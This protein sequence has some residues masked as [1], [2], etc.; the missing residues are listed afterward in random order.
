MTVNATIYTARITDVSLSFLSLTSYN[1]ADQEQNRGTHTVKS[2]ST[3][4][5]AD[6]AA[7]RLFAFLSQANSN[8]Q[9][10]IRTKKGHK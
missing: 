3:N 1:N 5:A 6:K 10:F 2:Y 7:H 8:G 4:T 9:S